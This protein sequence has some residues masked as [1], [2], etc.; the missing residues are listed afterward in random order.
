QWRGSVGCFDRCMWDW[1]CARNLEEIAAMAA[2][3]TPERSPASRRTLL[4]GALGGAVALVFQALGRPLRAQ[5]EG[6]SIAVGG[7]YTD[8][9]TATVIANTTNDESVLHGL[10]YADGVGIYGLSH[11]KRG[12]HGDSN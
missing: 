3:L 11:S 1:R 2:P 9:T 12:V 8:A 7:S 4:A 5:A 6:E 10:S